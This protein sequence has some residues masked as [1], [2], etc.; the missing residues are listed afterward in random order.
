MKESKERQKIKIGL[1]TYAI[2]GRKAKGTAIVARKAV[3]AFLERQG[4]FEITYLH[5]EKCDDGIYKHGCKEIVFPEFNKKCLNF[6]NF[7]FLRQVY[8]Y[9]SCKER[10]D[11]ILWF[12]PR[13]YPFFWLAPADRLVAILHGAGDTYVK[14]WNLG[15]LMF[16]W[17]L[18][19]FGWKLDLSIAVSNDA[20]IDLISNYNLDQ[21]KVCVV[22]NG[23]DNIFHVL[24]NREVVNKY[25]TIKY[26]FP[27]K[28]LLCVSRWDP[29]KNILN[30]IKGYS[31]YHR[32]SKVKNMLV[33]V[34]GKHNVEYSKEVEQLIVNENL[35]DRIYLA[36]YIDTEDMPKVYQGAEVSIFPSINEGF[37][38]PI[39]ESFASKCL[40]ICSEISVFKEIAQN[41]A[42]Y[43]NPND[44]V[45]IKNSIIQAENLDELTKRQMVLHEQKISEKFTW[46][47]MQAQT[48][49]SILT[50]V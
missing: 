19:L 7:R 10:Y 13:L 38:L 32:E 33:F 14:D 41:A 40:V 22:Y 15:R 1:M 39:I 6:L 29:H 35:Q 3:E 25:L 43:F 8:W 45:S 23:I 26:N 12:Q 47:E 5:Y 44:H 30:L 50:V 9:I 42:I 49:K 34:G 27:D 37:G 2:D 18:K 46:K 36:P 24:E 21:D 11:I 20:R 31:L 48:I 16:V 4:Q 28:Y 17:V